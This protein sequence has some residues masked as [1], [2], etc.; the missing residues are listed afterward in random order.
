MNVCV[1]I[2]ICTVYTFVRVYVHAHLHMHVYMYN[3]THTHTGHISCIFI[4][5]LTPVVYHSM[6]FDLQLAFPFL[7]FLNMI[8]M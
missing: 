8:D 7:F 2:C 1:H 3:Y 6:H 5:F 4:D